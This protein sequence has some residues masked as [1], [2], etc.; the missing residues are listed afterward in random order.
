MAKGQLVGKFMTYYEAPHIVAELSL[1]IT[2]AR[3]LGFGVEHLHAER[4][5]QRL[6][7]IVDSSEDA[8]VSKDLDGIIRT[9]NRG[10]ERLFGYAAEEVVGK[11][12]TVLIPTGRHN[13]EPQ[14]LERIR[15][16]E[17]VDH[18]EIVRLRKDGTLIDISLT[19][20]CQGRLRQRYRC[21]E[22]RPG[23]QRTK[24]GAGTPGAADEENPSPHQDLFGGAG[25][26]LPQLCG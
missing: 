16:R 18:Y 11:S 20:A 23:H 14:M 2:I 9:W 15:R 5:A 26:D 19:V 10:A 24:E 4:A 6:A 7:A 12:I 1:A 22:D 3:Q 21:I 25:G 17:P 8:I 13:E